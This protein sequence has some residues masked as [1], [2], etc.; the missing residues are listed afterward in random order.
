MI[1]TLDLTLMLK[2]A[3]DSSRESETAQALRAG[4]TSCAGLQFVVRMSA[5]LRVSL[6]PLRCFPYASQHRN[7]EANFI[8]EFLSN[9]FEVIGNAMVS[10]EGLEPSTP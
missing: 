9:V 4:R 7:G 1:A 8:A 5:G 10:A 3:I 2:D 6:S